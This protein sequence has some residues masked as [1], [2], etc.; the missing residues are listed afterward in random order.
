MVLPI[1]PC[2]VK[3]RPETECNLC[4]F[5]PINCHRDLMARVK[6]PWKEHVFFHNRHVPNEVKLDYLN[7]PSLYVAVNEEQ[8]TQL[9]RETN[10]TR[11]IKCV[12]V[13]NGELT[14]QSISEAFS[15]FEEDRVI[16]LHLIH[17]DIV[18]NMFYLF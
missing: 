9:L 4:G 3:E 16:R 17:N 2:Y 14:K 7:S 15:K 13:A 8:C 5:Q 12:Y 18:D 6:L 11:T 10:T 1:F